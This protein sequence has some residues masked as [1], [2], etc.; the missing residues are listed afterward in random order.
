[1]KYIKKHSLIL[2]LSLFI[3]ISSCKEKSDGVISPEDRIAFDGA[4][5]D[6]FFEKHFDF[7]KYEKDINALYN[8][9]DF[10]YVW[11]DKDGRVDFAEVLYSKVNEI[12]ED[13]VVQ[14]MSYKKEIDKLYTEKKGEKSTLENDL[15]VSAMYFYYTKNVL[16]GVDTKTSKQTG[17]Y[18]PRQNVSYVDYLADLIK[19]PEKLEEDA[20][21]N[22]DQ[23]YLLKKGL[24]KHH[25]IQKKG[26]WGTIDFPTNVKSLKEGDSAVVIAQIRKRLFLSG[27]LKSDSG[28][29]RFDSELKKGLTKYEMRHNR[30]VDGIIRASLVKE[31]NIPIEDRIKTIIVNMERCRWMNPK[32]MNAKELV[33]VN[34][35][36]YK[37]NYVKDGK[38]VLESNVVVGKEMNKTVIFSG[39]ISYLVFAPYWNVPTSI[40]EKEIKPAIA[41]NANYLEEKNMEW[42]EGRI[43][44][45]PGNTNSL[46][47]VKF[48]FPNQNAIYLHD[49]PAKRLFNKESR[50]FSHGCVR[51]EKARDLAVA[52][53]DGQNKMSASEIDKA[54][55]SGTEKSVALA[56]KIPVYIAYFTAWAD[57]DGNVNFYEDIYNR[58]NRLAKLLYKK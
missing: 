41:K 48:M 35:P 51:V 1:M 19:D 50:A 4:K 29:K 14:Q 44:Q 11:F 12:K 31:L 45:K 47:L 22:I 39:E 3:S 53:M 16:E 7:K 54:M 21:K 5:L 49:S 40:T 9:E 6:A 28:K 57:K 27:D 26:G 18:L 2:L 55:Q 37:M 23:Y 34:I 30:K 46:G 38:S 17:W 33:A 32:V 36:S 52:I 56:R 58:D 10:H 13:G 15:L 43:R 42:H 24:K 8:K 20:S 25:E